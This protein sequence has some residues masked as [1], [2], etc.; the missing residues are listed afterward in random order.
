MTDEPC[1]DHGSPAQHRLLLDGTVL[2]GVTGIAWTCGALLGAAI[3]AGGLRPALHQVGERADRARQRWAPPRTVRVVAS[4]W[5][6]ERTA[7]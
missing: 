3:G 7:E 2:L 6:A 1:L 5:P 4:D